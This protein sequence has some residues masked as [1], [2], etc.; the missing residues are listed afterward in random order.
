[1]PGADLRPKILV[2]EDDADVRRVICRIVE[3]AGYE[4]IGA[5]DGIYGMEALEKHTFVL[6]ITDLVMPRQE[7]LETIGLIKA[8][9]P[10]LPILAVSSVFDA[11][12]SP[13]DRAEQV[14]ADGI[15]AKPFTPDELTAAVKKLV[16]RPSGDP[17]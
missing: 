2:I 14:G 3:N 10:E 12:Y 9:H 16:R 1:M 15:L 5:A 6:V 8:L 17:G 11:D 7:G 13:L 4:P